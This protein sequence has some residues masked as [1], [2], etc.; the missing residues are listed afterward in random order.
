VTGVFKTINFVNTLVLQYGKQNKEIII[1]NSNKHF[2]S[3]FTH[4]LLQF[5][6]SKQI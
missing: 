4:T 2:H 1:Y 3:S 5:C 6:F